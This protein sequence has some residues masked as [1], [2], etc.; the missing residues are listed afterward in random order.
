MTLSD[1]FTIK[2]LPIHSEGCNHKTYYLFFDKIGIGRF[3]CKCVIDALKV[4][5]TS[6]RNN[7][8]IFQEETQAPESEES[9]E[10]SEDSAE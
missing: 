4:K 2:D 9:S 5:L 7:N 8:M 10:D 1:Y 3:G 6:Q